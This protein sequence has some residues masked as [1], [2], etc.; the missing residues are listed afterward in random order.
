MQQFEIYDSEGSFHYQMRAPDRR[1]PQ[2]PVDGGIDPSWT[3]HLWHPDLGQRG[4]HTIPHSRLE[5][6]VVQHGIDI[7][8]VRT[9]VGTILHWQHLPDPADPL[10]W[11]K[12]DTAKALEA[13]EDIPDPTW[14]PDMPAAEKAA[15]SAARVQAVR[16]HAVALDP[17]SLEDRAGALAARAYAVEAERQFAEMRGQ[18]FNQA[19]LLGIDDE[20]PEHPLDPIANS[21]R[22]DPARVEAFRGCEQWMAGMRERPHSRET[23]MKGPGLVA[24]RRRVPPVVVA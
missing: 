16:E 11:D 23:A 3:I 20:A 1:D 9:L 6:T 2:P 15:C 14:H 10:A 13:I 22:L 7:E 21:C 18:W 8:D 17:A 12:E 19:Y 4:F 5:A 24:S